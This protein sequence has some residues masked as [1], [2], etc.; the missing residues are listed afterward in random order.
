MTAAIFTMSTEKHPFEPF[1]PE[2]A[3]IL[4]LGSFPPQAHR[5]CMPFYYPNWIND[6]WRI[7]GLIHFG[8]KDHFCVPGEK[9]FDEAAIRAFCASEGFAFYDTA[10]EVRRL[11]DNA[12]D[13]F[14]EVVQ[15]TDIP[16][17]LARI[18]SCRVLVTTGQKATELAAEALHCPLPPVGEYIE[19][20]TLRFW[21]MP[22]T[23]RAYPLPLEKK[24][25]AYRQLFQKKLI[26]FDLDGTLLDTLEDLG[27]AVNQAL[28]ARGLPTHTADEYR[29]MVGHGIRSLVAQALPENPDAALVEAAL[30][31]FKSGYSAHIDERTRPYPGI[32]ELL[33]ELHA[34]GIRLAVASNKFQAGAER[35]I[36]RF[37]PGIPFVAI[38][39][40][41]PGSP[42]KPSPEI[43]R[44]VLEKA[45][46]GPQEA[47]LV[48]DSPTDIRTA[49]NGGIDALAVT[50]GYRS[51]EALAG[52]RLVDSVDELRHVLRFSY[53]CAEKPFQQ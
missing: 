35:L 51:R 27:A 40:D 4:F 15:P 38:L 45:G 43:V 34:N 18:P 8:D 41:R 36:R 52:Y 48:G 17:L 3:R 37:F 29:R 22:S 50:W 44:E 26:L 46:C 16:A 28:A 24:A 1:L 9:R 6:F 53:L 14:L 39:G 7:L 19:I 12:S 25:A 5:W 11:K 2:G 31:D 47:L 49:A 20:E 32:P 21:R 10:C 42:L 23:S 30:A 33:A 13:A